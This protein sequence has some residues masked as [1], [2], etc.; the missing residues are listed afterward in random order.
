MNDVNI[1]SA[2]VE[3][4]VHVIISEWSMKQKAQADIIRRIQSVG[5]L[6]E[7]ETTELLNVP[8]ITIENNYI[9]ST[10]FA[11]GRGTG[12]FIELRIS[13]DRSV[14]IAEFGQLEFTGEPWDVDWWIEEEYP[15]YSLLYKRLEFPRDVVL[16]HRVGK[17]GLIG[18]GVPLEGI[19]LGT[20]LQSVP[21]APSDMSPFSLSARLSIVDGF[22][23]CHWGQLQLHFDHRLGALPKRKKSSLF[24]PGESPVQWVLGNVEPGEIGDQKPSPLAN[25]PMNLGTPNVG[26]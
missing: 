20:C 14:H 2:T 9:N 3:N 15:I 16:N 12:F 26:K 7:I 17:L 13:S 18:P 10:A 6:N 5:Y 23:T 1:L 19:L 25:P 11:L 24:G 21:S 4:V 8:K 22:G